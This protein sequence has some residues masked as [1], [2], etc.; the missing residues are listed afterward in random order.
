MKAA[1]RV[2]PDVQGSLIKGFYFLKVL[3]LLIDFRQ[4]IECPG[5]IQMVWSQSFFLDLQ[6]LKII[7]FGAVI[8]PADSIDIGQIIQGVHNIR[9]NSL[10]RLNL[11][12]T[13]FRILFIVTPSSRR[14]E[15]ELGV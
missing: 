2:F 6:R 9:I 3:F 11:K 1:K 12:P 15:L 7:G 14:S 4:I 8:K 10:G 13:V 5:N